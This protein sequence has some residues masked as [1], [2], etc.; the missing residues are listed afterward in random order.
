MMSKIFIDTNILVYAMDNHD[1]D[2]QLTCRLKIKEAAENNLS[3]IST[4]VIQEFYVTA[5]KKLGADPLR[6]KDLIHSFQNFEIITISTD[7]INEA[8]DC[9]ILNRLSFWDSL[10]VTAAEQGKCQ[11]LWTEDLTHGQLIRGV[12]VVNPLKTGL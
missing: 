8:I 3:V 11:Y 9:S 1:R 12:Q 2:K 4:Q 7:M 10:I 6:V 5:T